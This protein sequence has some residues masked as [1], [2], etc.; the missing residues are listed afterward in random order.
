MPI[1]FF[2]SASILLLTLSAI[3]FANSTLAQPPTAQESAQGDEAFEKAMES[4]STALRSLR[5]SKFNPDAQADNLK[6][7]QKLEMALL[8]AKANMDSINMS[9]N[10]K[11]KFGTDKK[12][13]HTAF[14]TDLI[15]A[16]MTS[17][18]LEMAILTNDTEKAKELFRNLGEI[19]N[20]SHDLF[21]ANE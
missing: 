16:L 17:L 10:A 4:A 11:T 18:Q 15:K 5:R 20:S 7:I 2:S 8:T 9:P 13:Y 1:R 12:A 19:R 14:R 3:L 6:A 21:E